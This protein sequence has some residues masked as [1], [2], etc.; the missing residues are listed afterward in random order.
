MIDFRNE[1]ISLV[2]KYLIRFLLI[3][4]VDYKNVLHLNQ[5]GLEYCRSQIPSNLIKTPGDIMAKHQS[6]F[7]VK[8]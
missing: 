2:F 5:I 1:I 3:L 6:R 7:Y 8:C 4:T